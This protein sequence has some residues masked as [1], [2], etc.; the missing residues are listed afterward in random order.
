MRWLLL[1]FVFSSQAFATRA[2]LIESYHS[3]YPWDHS[4]IQ[5]IT[6]TLTETIELDTFQ[7]D[8]K[9]IPR[10]SY[11]GKAIE[12][13]AK[14]KS[15]KPDIVI[16]GDDN[17]FSYMLPMLFD[18][19]ISIVFLGINSNP[20]KLLSKYR[21]QAKVTGVLERPLFT[22]SLVELKK[23]FGDQDLK[24]KVLFDSGVTSQISKN[25]IKKQ[26]TMIRDNL[27]IKVDMKNIATLKAWQREVMEAK[28]DGF[29]VIIVGLY[30]TLVDERGNNVP[31]E[32]V[33]HWTNQ[34]S[35]LPLFAFWDFAVGKQKAVGGVVLFGYSQGEQAAQL[36]NK[37]AGSGHS[38]PILMVT[39][40]KGK[41]IYS[42]SEIAKW[43]IEIPSHWHSVD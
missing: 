2:L 20:R 36:V 9:R 38:Q 4:Y 31:A 17:A 25:Y 33:I 21:G 27:G 14:Y 23:L 30:Q 37:I 22:K 11:A 39:G 24:V 6:A 15:F 32:Q 16:L 7:M 43:N 42:E 13:Y 34:H 1:C 12:A 29:K 26:Y 3:E 40:N 5:G 10:S 35:E 41:A 19:P 28:N 8:T 18:E